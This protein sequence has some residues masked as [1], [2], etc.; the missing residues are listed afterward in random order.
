MQKFRALLLPLAIVFG[1]IAVFETGTRYGMTNM[2]AYAIAEQLHSLTQ[3]RITIQ[4][5][6]QGTA[7]LPVVPIA[8][9]DNLIASGSMLREIWHLEKNAKQVLENT[10]SFVMR[11][12]GAE[13]IIQ[14]FEAARDSEGTTAAN[15]T[16]FN[17]IIA[18]IQLARTELIDNAPTPVAS[19]TD[20]V[21]ADEPAAETSGASA[22]E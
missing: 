12:R 21:L 20:G 14:R 1:A 10:L 18:A 2:R 8:Q 22:A 4:N 17:E 13:N 16:Q 7:Q 5:E 19:E 11:A 6:E 15:Q 9:I 3:I